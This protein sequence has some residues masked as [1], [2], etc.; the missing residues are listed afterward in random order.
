MLLTATQ[1]MSLGRIQIMY[2]GQRLNVTGQRSECG[3]QRAAPIHE[4]VRQRMALCT[5]NQHN[6]MENQNTGAISPT[7]L[8]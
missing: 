6:P 1:T 3:G 8:Y 7:A 5:H 4:Q 2:Q